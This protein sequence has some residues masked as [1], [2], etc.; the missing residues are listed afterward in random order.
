MLSA[1]NVLS[2]DIN[3]MLP[4]VLQIAT[5]ACPI[6][7]PLSRVPD[8]LRP[9]YMLN[10]MAIVIDGYRQVILRGTLPAPEYVALAAVISIAV[11]FLGVWVFRRLEDQFADVI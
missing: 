2:R 6:I 8:F 4:L 1:L 5:Y 7:Y 9:F 3:Q 10:P 11:L